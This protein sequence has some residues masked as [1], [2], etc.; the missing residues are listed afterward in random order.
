MAPNIREEKIP[1]TGGNTNGGK[2]G[3]PYLQPVTV[4]LKMQAGTMEP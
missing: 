1:T 4:F 3:K 2:M